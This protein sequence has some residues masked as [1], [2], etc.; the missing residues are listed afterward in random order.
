MERAT[1]H[2][3]T[4]LPPPP[5]KNRAPC[6]PPLKIPESLLK[7]FSLLLPVPAPPPG[8]IRAGARRGSRACLV[9]DTNDE[10]NTWG[11]QGQRLYQRCNSG[12]IAATWRVT[13]ALQAL[14]VGC[15]I[16]RAR[17][18]HGSAPENI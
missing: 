17:H 1:D 4:F 7:F 12:H 2:R 15:A 11:A 14:P 13:A 8:A 5:Y 3:Q 9:T 16:G 18:R 6:L 10:N